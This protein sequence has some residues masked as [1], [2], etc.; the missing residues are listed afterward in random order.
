MN[1]LKAKADGPADRSGSKPVYLTPEQILAQI[2]HGVH[3]TLNPWKV[4]L[5]QK[6]MDNLIDLMN[7]FKARYSTETGMD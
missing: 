5:T 4:K 6:D 3:T 1:T 7:E 2:P